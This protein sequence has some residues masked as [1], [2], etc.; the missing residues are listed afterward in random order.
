MNDPST[1]DQPTPTQLVPATAEPIETKEELSP[2]E[3][4]AQI[5]IG[6]AA[7]FFRLGM[8]LFVLLSVLLSLFLSGCQVQAGETVPWHPATRVMTTEQIR[9]ILV[10]QS[11]YEP[12]TLPPEWIEAAEVYQM[13][14]ILF[15]NFNQP[16]ALCSPQGNRCWYSAFVEE[17]DTI[18]PVF[19]RLLNPHLPE[20]V[21]L[22]QP[23][24]TTLN[25]FPCF[26]VNQL[27]QQENEVQ[28]SRYCY[29]TQ[30]REFIQQGTT[31]VN[32]EN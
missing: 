23:T 26:E 21:P 28:R 17:G 16:D 18:R 10:N 31:V 32:D 9:E 2:E 24:E 19:S 15:F 30:T 29:D 13:G 3:L 20:G 11:T 8:G 25:E 4:A 7:N 22:F 27:G 6:K 12:N 1:S 5:Q 14:S